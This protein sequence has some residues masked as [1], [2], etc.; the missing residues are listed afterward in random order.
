MFLLQEIVIVNLLEP[1]G[2]QIADLLANEG[3]EIEIGEEMSYHS[4]VTYIPYVFLH[5]C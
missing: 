1:Y 4:F 2:A 5:E 3:A